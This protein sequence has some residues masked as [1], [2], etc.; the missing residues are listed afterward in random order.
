MHLLEQPCFG[1]AVFCGKIQA[2]LLSGS[3]SALCREGKAWLNRNLLE[4]K[5]GLLRLKKMAES[6]GVFGPGFAD[7]YLKIIFL[8]KWVALMVR[9]KIWWADAVFTKCFLYL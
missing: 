2:D 3:L 1:R 9:K 4:G 5:N 6:G 7:A 8:F